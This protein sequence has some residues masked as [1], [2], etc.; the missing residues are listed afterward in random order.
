MYS[1]QPRYQNKNDSNAQNLKN[2][3]F[4]FHFKKFTNEKSKNK[5]NELFADIT[6][7]ISRS[8]SKY[9]LPLP[10]FDNY[11]LIRTSNDS[12]KIDFLN[13]KMV[14]IAKRMDNEKICDD[15]P[16]E[17]I[18]RYIIQVVTDKTA[19]S[20]LTN[21]KKIANVVVQANSLDTNNRYNIITKENVIDFY[22]HFFI[23][24]YQNYGEWIQHPSLVACSTTWRHLTSEMILEKQNKTVEIAELTIASAFDEFILEI[25]RGIKWDQTTPETEAFDKS[26]LKKMN[27]LTS[28]SDMTRANRI[29][30]DI[31]EKHSAKERNSQLFQV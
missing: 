11:K 13:Q 6:S 20:I 9:Q 23:Y 30:V 2:I 15:L 26:Y 18:A 1:E 31:I 27:Q 5:A 14:E 16:C 25:T 22:V 28:P 19:N 7:L 10:T 3:F 8:R 4:G 12:I 21:I 24:F 17:E 29:I